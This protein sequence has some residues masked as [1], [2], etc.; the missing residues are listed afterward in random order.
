M[1]MKMNHT[2]IAAD[3][4]AIRTVASRTVSFGAASSGRFL[5][6]I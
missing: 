2:G 5:A 3:G 6:A 1:M 4:E